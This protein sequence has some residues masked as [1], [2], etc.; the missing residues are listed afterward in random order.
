MGCSVDSE[1]VVAVELAAL[2]GDLDLQ[3]TG[4]VLSGQGFFVFD[5]LGR[6]PFDHHFTTTNAR[7]W[8]KVDQV[9]RRPHRVFIVFNYH[10]RVTQ[11]TQVLKGIDQA[12]VVTGMQTNRRFVQNVQYAN[13]PGTDLTG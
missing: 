7:P 5:D 4:Q 12:V 11:V 3:A 6:V 9:V 1:N 2:I 13:Q 8:S 10:N